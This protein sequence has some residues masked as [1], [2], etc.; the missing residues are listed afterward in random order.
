MDPESAEKA[1][2]KIL[3]LV[4]G[5]GAMF[6]DGTDPELRIRLTREAGLEP[7]EFRFKEIYDH[8]RKHISYN[9][10]KHYYG[11]EPYLFFKKDKVRRY[12]TIFFVSN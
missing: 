9:W 6:I 1:F 2:W 10:W 3:K 5:N 11:R 12:G 4:R 7:L 8:T